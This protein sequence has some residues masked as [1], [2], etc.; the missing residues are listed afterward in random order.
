[1]VV[2]E[3]VR[4][5]GDEGD[6][7]VLGG[8]SAVVDRTEVAAVSS[9]VVIGDASGAGGAGSLTSLSDEHAYATSAETF[10]ADATVKIFVFIARNLM[11]GYIPDLTTAGSQTIGNQP[12]AAY[13]AA[14]PC[15]QNRTKKERGFLC[16][17]LC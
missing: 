15:S 5:V 1:M 9:S 4:A 7:E 12:L 11:C 14:P 13:S 10:S 17:H 6:A 3:V 2:V 16:V 8:G